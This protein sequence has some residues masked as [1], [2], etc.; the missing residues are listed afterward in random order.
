[1]ETKINSYLE[2]SIIEN[3][4]L[5][6]S[7]EGYFFIIDKTNGNILRSTSIL[8]SIKNKNVYPT[9]F[10]VAKNFVYVS[11]S[12][13]R[14]IKASILD[15]KV[16]NIIKIDGDRISRPHILGK[17]MYILRNDAIIKVE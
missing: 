1:M 11:L 14:L 10:I 3:F 17:K 12:N 15:G 13:G 8:D 6:I 9:G 2:P 4:V 16:K 7:E 5:T